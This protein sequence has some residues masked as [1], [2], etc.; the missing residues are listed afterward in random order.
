MKRWLLVKLFLIVL[1]AAAAGY[2]DSPLAKGFK[3]GQIE[4]DLKIHRGLDLAGGTRLVYEADL[5][6]IGD[7]KPADA[8]AGVI[9]V[10]DRRINALGVTEPLIQTTQI[11]DKR[12]VVVELP[13]IRNVEEAINL[14]GRTAQLEFWE[15]GTLSVQGGEL[16]F[17]PTDLTGA[18]LVEAR[19]D[20]QS[21]GVQT[22][23]RRLGQEPVVALKFN[24][25][26]TKK[27]SEITRR[28]LGKPL[29]IIIDGQTISA[30]TVQTTID[31]GNA[32]ITGI[33][34]IKEAKQLAIALQ[35]G[36]LPVPINLVAQSTIGP[37]LGQTSIERSIM[38][39]L[40]GLVLVVIFM[41]SYY[42]LSGLYASLALMI[43][44]LIVLALFKLIPVTVTLAGMTAFILSIGMAVDANIL[45]FERLKEERRKDKPLQAAI[46]EG[47]SRAWSSIRDSNVSSIITAVILFWFGS[48]M[49]RGFALTLIIGILVSMFTAINVSKIFLKL[50]LRERKLVG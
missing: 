19:L 28:N 29:A 3:W 44:A 1:L 36:A 13:G 42:R 21:G 24:A 25:E 14:I 37:T 50:F 7:R 23:S 20:I 26:G 34:D 35:A 4:R 39:G 16:G 47:F 5:S 8:I 40:I 33:E 41:I 43:Y 17:Q 27:F 49:I 18:D 38:A 46:D 15:Q 11:S 48:S 6:G 10:I 32:I 45:I 31:N 30:P 2:L 9:N 22:T 12:G